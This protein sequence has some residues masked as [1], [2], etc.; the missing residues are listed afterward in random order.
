MLPVDDPEVLAAGSSP[1]LALQVV[2]LTEEHRAAR[3]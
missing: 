3:C 2:V 1:V